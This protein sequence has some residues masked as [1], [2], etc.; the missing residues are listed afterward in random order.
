MRRTAVSLTAARPSRGGSRGAD[1]DVRAIHRR[2]IHGHGGDGC[3]RPVH[4]KTPGG[5]RSLLEITEGY[6]GDPKLMTSLRHRVPR[7]AGLPPQ[8]GHRG[9][10]PVLQPLRA[11]R[12]AGAIGQAFVAYI[13]HE[14][15]IGLSKLVRMVHLFTKRFTLQ[16]RI[17]QQIADSLGGGAAADTVWPCTCERSTCAR[18]MGA[19]LRRVAAADAPPTGAATTKPPTHSAEFLAACGMQR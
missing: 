11:P 14:H 5:T 19:A 16:E 4:A 9:A 8:P 6:E 3:H 18:K 15:I 2:D 13:A 12:P 1:G 17:G 10:D 7:R